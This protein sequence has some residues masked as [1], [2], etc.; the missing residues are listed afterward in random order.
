MRVQIYLCLLASSYSKSFFSTEEE[1]LEDSG[2]VAAGSYWTYL[3]YESENI[4]GPEGSE[5][6]MAFQEPAD[7]SNIVED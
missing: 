3:G 1:D 6:Q 5:H 2:R 4:E 7:E